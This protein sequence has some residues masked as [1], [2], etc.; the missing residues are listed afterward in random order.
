MPSPPSPTTIP[1]T[2]ADARTSP[3][4]VISVWHRLR[5]GGVGISVMNKAVLSSFTDGE[6]ACVSRFCIGNGPT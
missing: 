4:W 2:R 5:R 3:T 6:L 1:W